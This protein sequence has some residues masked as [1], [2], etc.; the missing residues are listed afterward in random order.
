MR[1]D[2]A[3]VR[4]RVQIGDHRAKRIVQ[5]DGVRIEQQQVSATGD[6][7]TEVVGPRK[8]DVFS[9]RQQRDLRIIALQALDRA[10]G[11]A[12]IDN[13][14]LNHRPPFDPLADRDGAPQN[15]VQAFH[16][17]RFDIPAYD[18]DR[19]IDQPVRLA[20]RRCP[21]SIPNLHSSRGSFILPLHLSATLTAVSDAVKEQTY[22]EAANHVAG[23]G[24]NRRDRRCVYRAGAGA[25][26]GWRNASGGDRSGRW[27]PA[28]FRYARA[29]GYARLSPRIR[30]A[31]ARFAT[32]VARRPER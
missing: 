25:A 19:K 23:A 20:V 7:Q 16:Q 32:S 9:L 14:D 17:Q 27:L 1:P 15:A 5:H 13:D 6:F 12:R 4:V 21:A 29:S 28:S 31:P 8:A 2:E 24:G 3:D 26:R 30:R 18:D 10:V 22:V 11:A